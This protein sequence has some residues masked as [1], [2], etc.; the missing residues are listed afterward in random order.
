MARQ[1]DE[2]ER[3]AQ[4]SSDGFVLSVS[5]FDE[6]QVCVDEILGR[7][8]AHPENSEARRVVFELVG[9]ARLFCRLRFLPRTVLI[10][11]FQDAL[12]HALGMNAREAAALFLP[13]CTVST[14]T[15]RTMTGH[16]PTRTCTPTMSLLKDQNNPQFEQF[17]ERVQ[18]LRAAPASSGPAS[19]CWFQLLCGVPAEPHSTWVRRISS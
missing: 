13:I 5:M 4:S 2:L 12:D 18:Q 11:W 9:F 3:L 15:F 10:P 7:V 8:R 16:K 14:C 6:Y 17:L 19:T 1:L